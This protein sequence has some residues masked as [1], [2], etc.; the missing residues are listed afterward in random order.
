M[1]IEE[2]YSIRKLERI[3]SMINNPFKETNYPF[4]FDNKI[5]M[6]QHKDMK[7]IIQTMKNLKADKVILCIDDISYNL[8]IKKY[9]GFSK[10]K[11]LK[12]RI[13]K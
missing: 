4:L 12:G 10:K 1:L 11:Q 8:S 13:K 7:F 6:L 3:E 2:I 9:N 5:Y